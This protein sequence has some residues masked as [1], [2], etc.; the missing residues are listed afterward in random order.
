MLKTGFRPILIWL[1]LPA[2]CVAGFGR[3]SAAAPGGLCF[4]GKGHVSCGDVFSAAAGTIEF[5]FKPAST[6]NNEWALSILKDKDNQLLIGFG[7]T[8]LLC[9]VRT[10]G[11][12][13]YVFSSKAAV[14]VNEWHHLAYTFSADTA[15]LFLDGVAYRSGKSGSFSLEHLRGSELLVGKG[16]RKEYFR[17]LVSE[18]RLSRCI[19][20]ADAFAPPV[21]PFVADADTV[22]LWHAAEP[23]GDTILDAGGR[24]RHGRIIG[25]VA[26]VEDTP[27]LAVEARALPCVRL[28]TPPVLDGDLGDACWHDAAAAADFCRPGSGGQTLAPGQ[29][30]VKARYD[31]AALYL[32]VTCHE[33]AMDELLALVTTRDGAV[34]KDDCVEIFL[35]VNADRA[36]AYH[37]GFNA[38]GTCADGISDC[39]GQFRYDRTWDSGAQA[40]ARRS[41]SHWTLEAAIPFR[42]LAAATPSQSTVWGFN[43]AREHRVAERVFFSTWSALPGAAFHSPKHFGYLRFTAEAVPPGLREVS[44]TALAIR[45][46]DFAERDAAGKLVAWQL[47]PGTSVAE[48][49]YLSGIY[50]LATESDDLMARQ[51]ANIW[52]V[53]GQAYDF[54]VLAEGTGDARL[55]LLLRYLDAAGGEHELPVI[56]DERVPPA[57]KDVSRSVAFPT[58]ARRL[59]AIELHR[60]SGRGRLR[61]SRVRAASAMLRFD[62]VRDAAEIFAEHRLPISEPWQSSGAEWGVPLAGGPL[63]VLFVSAAQ[64]IREVAELA[65]RIEMR[66]DLCWVKD[67]EVLA[68]NAEQI[69]ARLRDPDGTYDTIVLS[70]PLTDRAFAQTLNAHIR[71]GTGLVLLRRTDDQAAVRGFEEAL[72]ELVELSSS[73]SELAWRVPWRHLPVMP[74]TPGGHNAARESC[75]KSVGVGRFGKGRVVHVGYGKPGGVRV[76]LPKTG[77]GGS[78]LPDW[79]E[80][81]YSFLARSVLEASGREMPAGIVSAA[82]ASDAGVV[83]AVV[84]AKA[85][86]EGKL[87]AVWHDKLSA[88]DAVEAHQRVSVTEPARVSLRIPIPA[89]VRRAHGLHVADLRLTAADGRTVDWASIAVDV[90]G[91]S[92]IADE[93]PLGSDVFAVGQV[94]HGT[95]RVHNRG[96]AA[97]RVRLQVQ[98]IDSHGRCVCS[99]TKA[100]HVPYA[101]TASVDIRLSQERCLTVYHSLVATLRDEHGVKDRRAWDVYLPDYAKRAWDDFLFGGNASYYRRSPTDGAMVRFLQSVGIGFASE[102]SVFQS[103][104][105]LNMPWHKFFIAWKPFHHHTGEAERRPCFSDPEAM[106]KIVAGALIEVERSRTFAPLFYTIGDEIELTRDGRTEVCFSPHCAR[107]FREWANTVH[108]SLEAANAEWGTSYR[109]WSEVGPVTAEEAR[110]RSNSAQW[111]DFRLFMDEVWNGAFVAVRDAVKRRY[112]DA[113]LSFS[114]PF[115]RNPFSGED[116]YRTAVAEDVHCKY[117]RPDLVK[118]CRSFNP[119]APMFSFYGYLEATPFCRYFPWHFALNGGDV[120][121]WWN[122]LDR[123]LPYDLFDGLCRHTARSR[124]VLETSADL[125]SGIGKILH[126]FPACRTPV[127]M[128]YSQA[129]MHVAW[130]ESDMRTGEIPWSQDRMD[131]LPL[132]NPFA[133]H[134]HSSGKFKALV[135]ET[136]L[137]PEMVTPGQIADGRL[138]AYR[139]LI[140]PC[141][142][143]LADETLSALTHFARAGGTVLADLRTGLTSDHGKPLAQRPLLHELFGFRRLSRD[144]DAE[145]AELSFA[146]RLASLPAATGADRGNGHERLKLTTGRAMARHRDGTP[147]LI[148]NECGRGKGVYLN[149]LAG[150][151]P[152]SVALMLEILQLAGV[153]RRVRLS[154][155]DQ[156]AI[157]YE[158]FEFARGQAKIVG[159]LRDLPPQAESERPSWFGPAYRHAVTERETVLAQLSAACHLYD[160]RAGRYLGYSA[161][162]PL[163]F[164]PCQAHVL[165]LL[166]YQVTGIALT[167]L[168]PTFEQ[169]DTLTFTAAVQTSTG[170]A[171]DHVVRVEVRGPDEKLVSC[172][173]RNVLAAG[174]KA[175]YTIPLALNA[176]PGAWHL[177]VTDA[178]SKVARSAQFLVETR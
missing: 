172:Y 108:G 63:R 115:L 65:Q 92:T 7:P 61:C 139:L 82:C 165:A 122:V 118:E 68:F 141:T 125:L 96:G 38:L 148:V 87:H 168:E 116:H 170:R 152:V 25:H 10:H 133:L 171:E 145:P 24:E 1:V 48:T 16:D 89:A 83:T 158:T 124:A 102:G 23:E 62:G 19:R 33:P 47:G 91:A 18:V 6:E 74:A 142:L 66:Y 162:V 127:A 153:E 90:S 175:T 73:D 169:G 105:R 85:R 39:R 26:R 177:E 160:V 173:T 146:G 140:L 126:D 130:I 79:W 46:A 76:L 103:A 75:L 49:A 107:R 120:L 69:N 44:N 129:S 67:G 119:S 20:Y 17:G 14:S 163:E 54:R 58:N 81:V 112:P 166:P 106:A 95:V 15:T 80:Y 155:T 110:K 32:G 60:S 117:M 78:D 64:S 151:G 98:L 53:A 5:W 41:G 3:A 31:D 77:T 57:C 101:Q 94:M 157:G 136:S 99:D 72:P 27:F 93:H 150:N 132:A 156:P 97:V 40:A 11:V 59:T 8:A 109:A 111:V 22:A 137:Q 131:Q 149:L 45:N 147:A 51:E 13:A 56:W 37:L 138:E 114:N 2:L 21:T 167:G 70:V 100:V 161:T 9:F 71:L 123:Q 154:R 174:G 29:T 28:G 50:A 84:T 34:F 36:T 52:G 30:L 164:E 104:A 55:G 88:V 86:F 178:V 42:A 4:A 135:K 121:A 134:F 43:V 35:D 143:A 113:L 176:T 144:Y 159:I 12:H 128:L